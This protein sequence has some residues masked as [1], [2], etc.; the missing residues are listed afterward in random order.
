MP[1]GPTG[2]R[3]TLT[4]API[5]I[6][7]ASIVNYGKVPYS[8]T[9]EAAFRESTPRGAGLSFSDRHCS[10]YLIESLISYVSAG[11]RHILRD[12]IRCDPPIQ[13]KVH[14]SLCTGRL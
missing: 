2:C 7:G 8:F 6:I 12:R 3:F 11:F 10:D 4:R 1:P 9:L 14:I 13:L 5:E